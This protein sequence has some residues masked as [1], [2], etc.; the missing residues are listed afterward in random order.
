MGKHNL[1]FKLNIQH[2]AA[3]PKL[4]DAEGLG[5]AISVDFTSRFGA[6]LKKFL[7]ALQIT[8]KVPM[9]VGTALHKY[10]MDVDGS[11]NNDGVVPEGDIIPL[12]R[13]TRK[14]LDIIALEFKKFRKSTSLEAIQSH[15]FDL[16]VTQTND[17]FLKYLQNG[18]RADFY[19]DL[20]ASATHE[21]RTNNEVITGSNLQGV[22][23]HLRANLETVADDDV[24]LLAMVN[25]YDVADHIADGSLNSM[26]AM[27][28][29]NILQDYTGTVIIPN[30]EVARGTVFATV[31]DN[32]VVPYIDV[33]GEVNK[34]F[35][36]VKDS[37][38]FIGVL[39]D[40]QPQRLTADTVAV[41]GVSLFAD[42]V[43]LVVTGTIEA[44]VEAPAEV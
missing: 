29:A 12:T 28:G 8:R 5:E 35:G 44:P 39:N 41:H 27:F 4:T 40:I 14:K 42:N 22:L 15:G 32:I 30:K 25:P 17:A 16:A 43:D 7:E 33:A 1:K 38:G 34:Q 3:E 21:L 23:A 20:F 10:G 24:Q 31:A 26:G 9:S 36:F 19:A 13:V 2:F 11:E 6:N 37:T 18:V